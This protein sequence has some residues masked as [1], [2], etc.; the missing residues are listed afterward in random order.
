[1]MRGATLHLSMQ[2][3]YKINLSRFLPRRTE[4]DFGSIP[5]ACSAAAQL[6]KVA[7]A[8]LT[9]A[10]YSRRALAYSQAESW[11]GAFS[12]VI[13]AILVVLQPET[14]LQQRPPSYLSK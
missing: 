5:A 2:G 8:A 4:Y 10:A 14:F 9:S 11:R 7:S 13:V 3:L 1:M 12:P 6:P